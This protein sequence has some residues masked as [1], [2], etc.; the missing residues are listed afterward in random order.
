MKQTQV[1]T[2][3]PTLQTVLMIEKTISKYSGELR[4]YQLWKK[5][6]KKVMYQT[7]KIVIG[8]LIES[9]KIMI[10][11]DGVIEW[12]WNPQLIK[13]LEKEMLIIK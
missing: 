2:F 3:N 4:V 9:H 7:Y 12:I 13:R 1:L 5:L 11:K 10:C 6:P 8:Y